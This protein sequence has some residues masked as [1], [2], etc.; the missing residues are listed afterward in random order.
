MLLRNQGARPYGLSG[1]IIGRWMNR[2]HTGLYAEYFRNNLPREDSVILD[3]GCG[4]GRFLRF[5]Y[6]SNTGY[7]LFGVDHSA[8]MI[9]LSKKVIKHRKG[10]QEPVNLLQAGVTYL[11]FPDSYFDLITAFETIQFW[12]DIDLA[13]NKVNRIL[14]KDGTFLIIN[15]YP[16]EGSRWWERALI[17]NE[18]EYQ[19]MLVNAGFFSVDINLN[20]KK[21]WIIVKANK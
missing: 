3:I 12:S 6:C 10:E 4:G 20:F 1:K 8:E 13:L 17:K 5:L 21:G 9:E 16:K 11:P 2:F 7:R 18:R 15:R 14:K 19:T